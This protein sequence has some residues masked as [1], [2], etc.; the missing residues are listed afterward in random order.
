[1]KTKMWSGEHCHNQR[2]C[3]TQSLRPTPSVLRR[4]GGTD[5]LNMV[6]RVGHMHT[7]IDSDEEPLVTLSHMPVAT[8]V[9][10]SALSSQA[11]T[12]QSP[13]VRSRRVS[14]RVIGEDAHE[15]QQVGATVEDDDSGQADWFSQSGHQSQVEGA[16]PCVM[17]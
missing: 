7:Q 1:M 5:D 2:C 10:G 15:Q 4:T 17:F 9:E 11:D 13:L 16:A 12:S 6:K 14:R 8:Q 3:L